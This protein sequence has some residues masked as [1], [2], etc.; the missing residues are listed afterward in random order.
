VSICE[1]KHRYATE[2]EALRA[3]V[4]IS[5]DEGL[6]IHRRRNGK[7]MEVW[8]Y[9]C[10]VC[11]GWHLTSHPIEGTPGFDLGDGPEAREGETG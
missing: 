6:K 8:F 4:A 1:G 7:R 9:S 11:D 2:P 5:L 3:L 10:P